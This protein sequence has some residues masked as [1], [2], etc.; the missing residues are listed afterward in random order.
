MLFSNFL[1]LDLSLHEWRVFL[2]V[3]SMYLPIGDDFLQLLEGDHMII[4]C[5]LI[6]DEEDTK[7]KLHLLIACS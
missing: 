4:A 7:G 5:L 3:I 2:F 1:L 6:S